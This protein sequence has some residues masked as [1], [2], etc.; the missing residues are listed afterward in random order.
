MRRWPIFVAVMYCLGGIA[1][2]AHFAWNN[3]SGLGNLSLQMYVLPVTLIG[4]VLGKI[5]GATELILIP[6]SLGY[7]PSNAVF[8]FPSVLLLAYLVGWR[9]PAIYRRMMED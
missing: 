5:V 6:K 1:A 3:A 9:F 7:L 4:V 2:W 8:F